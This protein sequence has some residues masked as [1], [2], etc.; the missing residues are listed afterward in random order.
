MAKRKKGSA[1]ATAVSALAAK[2]LPCLATSAAAR[3]AA[4]MAAQLQAPI[5][6]Q[7]TIAAQTLAEGASHLSPKG[8]HASLANTNVSRTDVLLDLP[9]G[10]H[11]SQEAKNPPLRC[12]LPHSN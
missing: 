7:R 8:H 2:P 4:F 5:E 6:Y 1:S 12:V 9:P 3:T 10:V 11:P